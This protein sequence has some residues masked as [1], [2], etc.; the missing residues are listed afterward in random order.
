MSDI[1]KRAKEAFEAWV[2]Y[3]YGSL[4]NFKYC[5]D[6]GEIER[7]FKAGFLCAQEIQILK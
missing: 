5:C 1:D 6:A 3:V 2:V 7:V 4:E